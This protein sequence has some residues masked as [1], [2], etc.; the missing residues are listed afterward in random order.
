M[1]QTQQLIEQVRAKLEGATDYKVAQVLDIPR[2]LLHYYIKGE[3][4]A[5]SY[6]CTR[7]DE[8]LERDPLEVIAQ[9]EAEAA[10]TEKK[11]AYWAGLPSGLKRTALGVAFLVTSGFFGAG[12]PAGAEASS[13]SHNVPLR[14]LRITHFGRTVRA[15]MRNI[16]YWR[17]WFGCCGC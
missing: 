5:D 14:H 3:R 4:H 2:N 15:W 6:A 7:F 10:R 8:V 9:V 12:L 1:T 16:G 13:A 11:R 17:G